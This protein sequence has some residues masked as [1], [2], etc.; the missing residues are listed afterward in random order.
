MLGRGQSVSEHQD[1]VQELPQSEALHLTTACGA[2]NLEGMLF[3]SLALFHPLYH[4][5]PLLLPQPVICQHPAQGWAQST[6][7]A[8]DSGPGLGRRVT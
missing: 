8:Q 7:C 4:V 3:P 1:W 5:C 2:M 6:C